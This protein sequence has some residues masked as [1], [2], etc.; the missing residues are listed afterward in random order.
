M[1]T[2]LGGISAFLFIAFVGFFAA[3]AYVYFT[4]DGITQVN[5]EDTTKAQPKATSNPCA[6]AQSLQ[7]CKELSK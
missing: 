6:F 1:R 3:H 7:H 4:H 5:F 2:F